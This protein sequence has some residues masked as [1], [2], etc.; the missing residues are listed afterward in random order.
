MD[1][2]GA[3]AALTRIPDGPP[4]EVDEN[5]ITQIISEWSS[6]PVGKLE[7]DEMDRLRALEENLASRVKGQARAVRS[8]AKAIRRAR[9]GVRNPQRPIAS[10]LFCGVS[11]TGKTHLCKTLADTYYGSERNLVRLDMSEYM[12]KFTVSRLTGPPPGFTG[13][14]SISCLLMKRAL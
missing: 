10:F 6:I 8:V 12:E 13:Y 5:L 3:L 2:A 9:T 1:E 7:L 4:P 14:V 11:G